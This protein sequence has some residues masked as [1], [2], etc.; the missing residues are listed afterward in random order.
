MEKLNYE[1]FKYLFL[2]HSKLIIALL[3]MLLLIIIFNIFKTAY[4]SRTEISEFDEIQQHLDDIYTKDKKIFNKTK[5][6]LIN[7]ESRGIDI[8]SWQGDIDWD[9]LSQTDIDFVIIRCGLRS[10]DTT[11][12]TED[13]NFKKNITE[14]NRLGIPVGV[15]FYSTAINEVEVLEEA[16]FVLNLIKDYQITYPI[17]Y[18]FELFDKKRTIGIS[19][20]TINSNALSFLEYI[21]KHGY[22]GMIYTNIT[23]ATYHWDER[24]FTNYHT[25]LAQYID[26]STYEGIFDMWQYADNGRIDG[27]KGS[28]DLNLSYITYKA[29]S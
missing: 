5:V 28:V 29:I 25:W 4:G 2:K 21:E 22:K 10:Q 9:K 8:S 18:D 16:S 24:L 1:K 3:V 20:E 19:D 12:I 14:A 11:T 13:K 27:I 17:A 26:Q 15:Y 23:N 6:E 7:E